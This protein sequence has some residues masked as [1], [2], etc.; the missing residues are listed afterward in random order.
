MAEV[1]MKTRAMNAFD[2]LFLGALIVQVFT[3]IAGW[4]WIAMEIHELIAMQGGG[5]DM[6]VF[7]SSM[8]PYFIAFDLFCGFALW[9]FISVFRWAF[10]RFVLAA[11]VALE[12]ISLVQEIVD[13]IGG[14]WF[15]ASGV[16]SV[17]LKITAVVF[18]FQSEAGAWLR[19][20]V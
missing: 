9:A 12:V 1:T 15:F 7:F 17:G 14:L 3:V 10:F 19:R 20:E 6:Q 13:P 18:V 4:D 8:V 5:P 16:L 2:Y 11:F